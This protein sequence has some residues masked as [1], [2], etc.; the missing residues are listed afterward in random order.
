MG[1]SPEFSLEISS[2][3]T[4]T[5]T[6]TQTRTAITRL[7]PSSLVTPPPYPLHTD[8]NVIRHLI[9][10]MNVRHVNVVLG[11]EYVQTCFQVSPW[12]YIFF[13]LP[14]VETF[15]QMLLILASKSAP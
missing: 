3:F 1:G 2:S 11:L 6:K 15:I 7:A 8:L 10:Y 9:C 14:S 13:R 5:N 12:F 4:P